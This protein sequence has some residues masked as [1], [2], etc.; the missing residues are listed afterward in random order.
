[1]H[2]RGGQAQ[3]NIRGQMMH[4]KWGTDEYKRANYAW[5]M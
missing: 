4:I 1:M 3:I 2:R 5:H